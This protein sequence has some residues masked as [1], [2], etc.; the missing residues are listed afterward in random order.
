MGADQEQ[1]VLCWVPLLMV[2][3]RNWGQYRGKLELMDYRVRWKEPG[4]FHLARRR[5]RG[6]VNSGCN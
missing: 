4:L 2:G 6:N 1:S 5:L 3:G